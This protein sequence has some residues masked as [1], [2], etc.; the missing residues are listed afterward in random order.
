[1]FGLG[2]LKALTLG[3]SHTITVINVKLCMMLLHIK[4]YLFVTLSV[5]LT[6]FEDHSLVKQF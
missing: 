5:I 2:L 1:M 6:L 4:L 3:F